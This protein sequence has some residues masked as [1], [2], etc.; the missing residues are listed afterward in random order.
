MPVTLKDVAKHAGVSYATVSRVLANKPNIADSTRQRVL[1]AVHQLDYRPNR[2][3][4]SLKAQRSEIIGLIISDIQYDFSPPLVRAVEDLASASGYGLFLCN[5]DE[6]PDKEMYYTE[7][8]IQENVS[9]VIIAPTHESNLAVQRLLD[10][11]IPIVVVDRRVQDAEVDTVVIDNFAAAYKLT[12]HL[13]ENGYQKIGAVFGSITAT[14]A[15]ERLEGFQ[16]ALKDA[17]LPINDHH[18][19][20]GSPRPEVGNQLT[21][22]ILTTTSPPEAILAS[23]HFLASGVFQAIKTLGLRIP[24]N[25]ALVAFDDSIW[26]A[27]VEPR[28]TVIAQPAYSIGETAAQLL[29]E[30][31]SKP[32]PPIQFITLDVELL[33]RESSGSFSN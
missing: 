31:I 4:R 3:A 33:V 17:D 26:T 11:N 19:R 6:N 2:T 29:L 32:N 21:R 12:H 28:L 20:I 8:L 5:S 27:L 16:Q 22:E 10:V 1:K 30:R 7:L 24:D 25:I 23:N 14:T 18:I 15:R 9:G 13:I